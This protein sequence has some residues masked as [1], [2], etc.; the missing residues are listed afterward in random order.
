MSRRW[1][2][3]ILATAH[4]FL[5]QFYR[6][7]NAVIAPELIR[8]LSLNTEELGLL[9]ASFFYGFA[10][11]QIPISV[12]LDK[13]GPRRLMTVLSLMGVV[14]AI[15][16]SIADSLGF[17]LIGRVL[18]G[19]GMACNLMGTFKLLTEWFE[20]LVFATLT[21]LVAS[22]GTLG[23]MVA[24]TPLVMLVEQ[25]GW[26][27]SFQLIAGINLILTLTLFMV[28]RD[29][30]A[31]SAIHSANDAPAISLRQAFSNLGFLFKNKDYWIISAA[32]LVRYGTFAAFQALWAGPFLIEVMGYSAMRTGNLI[33]LMNVGLII[34]SPL[35]GALSDR[36]FKTRKGLVV[37]CLLMM[38][39]I[40]L[41]LTTFSAETG[42]F[43]ISLVFFLFGLAASGGMLMYPHI[44]DLMPRD[45]SGAAMTG[46][47]FFNMLGP[48]VFLQG[49]GTFMQHL[50]PDASRGPAAFDAS[51]L[52]CMLCLIGA[53]ALYMF[54]AAKQD[55]KLN[56]SL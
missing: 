53:T 24:A 48:A 45:M 25:F 46:I 43:I 11:T 22:I 56:K 2:I 16:F 21:G 41:A 15:L 26:R 28:V 40:S 52:V 9:S 37:F 1:I 19:I 8:D 5:S 39:L 42:L 12:L 4:F 36:V 47:N 13:V 10:L 54:T 31:R 29:R 50:Y 30:P 44:K 34:G 27:L 18:L 35:W 33:L 38:A 14:G 55:V 51:F 49:L 7:S 23:N 17:G 20:P 3:F 32:T 6:T